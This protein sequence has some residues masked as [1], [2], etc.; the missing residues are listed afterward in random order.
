MKRFGYL[1]GL[2]AIL[3]GSEALAQRAVDH[4]TAAAR[5][6]RY[7]GPC[8]AS[9]EFVGTIYVNFPT[10]VTFRWERSDGATGRVE[11]ARINPTGSVVTRWQL[12]RR[13][14]EVFRGSETL[15]VL[16]PGDFFSNPAEFTLVCR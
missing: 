4:V 8:P 15:H 16:S 1:F 13:P 5:P 3:Q 11:S 9:I 7:D 12:S 6:G 10:T 14:G 2:I